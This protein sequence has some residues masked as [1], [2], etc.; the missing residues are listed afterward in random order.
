MLRFPGVCVCPRRG[1]SEGPVGIRRFDPCAAGEALRLEES[2]SLSPRTRRELVQKKLIGAS[3]RQ[4]TVLERL[5]RV[6]EEQQAV[7]SPTSVA[8]AAAAAAA[9]AAV[10]DTVRGDFARVRAAVLAGVEVRPRRGEGEPGK[11][12]PAGLLVRSGASGSP[13]SGSEDSDG[14]SAP[15]EHGSQTDL[16]AGSIFLTRLPTAMTN[17]RGGDRQQKSSRHR[18]A[19]SAAS[20]AAASVTPEGA[21]AR[22]ALLRRLHAAIDGSYQVLLEAAAERRAGVCGGRGAGLRLGQ[23]VGPPE[24]LDCLRAWLYVR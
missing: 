17:R 10:Q 19:A 16:S 20:R 3:L 2:M 5:R 12:A 22:T 15:A 8:A 6:Q 13:A 4:L 9:R 18:P 24:L 21:A 11:G 7:P 1:S 14:G 23:H